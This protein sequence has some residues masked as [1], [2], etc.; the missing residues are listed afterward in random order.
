MKERFETLYNML[1]LDRK[2]SEWSS[3]N[4]FEIRAEE[5][6]KEVAEIR[7]AIKN[8]DIENLK[9]EL[10][11][12][13]WDLLFLIVIAEEKQIFTAQDV[14]DGAIQKL[15]RRKPWIFN[16]EKLTKE[17]EHRRWLEIK[18]IEKNLKG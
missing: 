4:T 13:L 12:T 2:N 8:N 1:K 18:R 9:E 14:I 7:L 11:D 17:E 10:G 6:E 3:L 5:L 16:G 15:Q